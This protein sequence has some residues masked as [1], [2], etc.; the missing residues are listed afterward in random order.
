MTTLKEIAELAGVAPSTVSRVLNNA[1]ANCASEKVRRRIWAAANQ[2]H[3]QPNQAARQLR[4]GNPTRQRCPGLAVVAA[5]FD[6]PE[7]DPFFAQLFR[8][9]EQQLFACGCSLTASLSSS[10][11]LRLPLP[12]VEGYLLL[13]RCSP[14]VLQRLCGCTEN[15][16]A[17][18]RNRTDF[19]V[20][21]VFC[22]GKQAASLAMEHLL[23]L[24]H[25]RIAYI[26]SCSYEE[27]FIGYYEA[28]LRHSLP[29][30]QGLVRDTDQTEPSGRAA[31]SQLLAQGGFSAALC[32]NDA[33]ALGA[34]Q[35]MSSC[36]AESIAVVGIDNIDA[37]ETVTPALT[38]VH[39][40]KEE[41]GRAA[42]N[43]LLDRLNGGHREHVRMEFPCRLIKR[44]SSPA[45][46]QTIAD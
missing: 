42:V 38:T 16:V 2:L 32:A 30:D 43:L 37:A 45:I 17:V 10:E 8:S 46:G 40:P 24:G 1:G 9:V 5:R 12:E 23:A 18:G 35:A 11:L 29:L 34:L 6:A 19:Q 20:D 36:G 28:L 7:S 39:I 4:Q 41:M 21:E 44:A 31:M 26:G 27:R 3:Y 22:S 13:G 33:T 15:I 25:R 14:E